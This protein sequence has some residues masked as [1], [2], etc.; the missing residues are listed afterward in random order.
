MPH[1]P[2]LARP[3]EPLCPGWRSARYRR[4]APQKDLNSAATLLAIIP[5]LPRPA[6]ARLTERL[7]DRMDE[8]D[9]DPDLEDARE[10]W[11]DDHDQEKEGAHD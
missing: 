4:W 3:P 11:E 5:S 8:I 9:G 6:L 2:A 7:V 10:A 1:M